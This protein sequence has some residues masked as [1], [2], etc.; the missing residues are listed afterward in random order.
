[1][2]IILNRL[3]DVIFTYQSCVVVSLA[4]HNTSQPA[5][6]T[7]FTQMCHS[8][9]TPANLSCTVASDRSKGIFEI[10]EDWRIAAIFIIALGMILQG[11]TKSPR[12]PLLSI[13]VDDNVPKTQTSVY[14][15]K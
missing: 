6:H 11:A 15:G 3:S 9:T 10:T 13:Y 4:G 14:L 2:V 1:M 8:F 12:Q 7:G 5:A